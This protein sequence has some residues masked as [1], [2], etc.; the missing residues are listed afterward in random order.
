MV[1]WSLLPFAVC[2]KR[3][4]KSPYY[5]MMGTSKGTFSDVPYILQ[6]SIFSEVQSGVESPSF[7]GRRRPK[8]KPV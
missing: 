2:R 4:V 5:L 8:K 3:D 1:T 7:P 6:V